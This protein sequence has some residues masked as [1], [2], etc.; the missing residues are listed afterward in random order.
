MFRN[1]VF[2]LMGAPRRSGRYRGLLHLARRWNVVRFLAC[3]GTALVVLG[4]TGILG[5]L[6]SLSRAE[7]FH[8]PHWVNWLHFGFGTFVWAAVLV[9]GRRLQQGL[10]FFGAVAGTALGLV[11]LVLH[12]YGVGP[13]AAQSGDLSDPLTHLAVGLLAIGALLNNRRDGYEEPEYPT[14]HS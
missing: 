6:G 7:L 12:A 13:G 4:V 10:A 2:G 1:A 3:G 8:P 14:A 5:W 9:G 11:D